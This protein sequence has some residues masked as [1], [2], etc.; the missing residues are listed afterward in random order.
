MKRIIHTDHAPSAIGPYSQAVEASGGK[1]IFLSGQI[2]LDP[3]SM[4]I[5]GEN[6]S[7]QCRQVMANLAEVLKAAG[8]DFTNLVKTT[9]Y[10]NDMNDF[11]AV[12]DVYAT[13]FDNEPPARATVEAARL[14][15]DVKVEIDAIA[16]V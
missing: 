10:L 3:T 5:V 2:A 6:A 12:N 13:Y 16:V 8:A 7:E 15:K 4:E 14:P 1:F 9:I 11:G